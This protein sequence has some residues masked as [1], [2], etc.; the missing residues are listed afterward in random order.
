MNSCNR[1]GTKPSVV[2]R[3]RRQTIDRTSVGRYAGIHRAQRGV[4]VFREAVAH[5][6]VQ[7]IDADLRNY[8]AHMHDAEVLAAQKSRE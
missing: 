2:V 3:L 4:K 8:V 5:R 1:F 6:V 7:Q